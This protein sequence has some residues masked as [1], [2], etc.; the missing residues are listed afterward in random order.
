[1]ERRKTM[2]KNCRGLRGTHS[3][4]GCQE[5]VTGGAWSCRRRTEADAPKILGEYDAVLWPCYVEDFEA[6][7]LSL[8]FCILTAKS[9]LWVTCCLCRIMLCHKMQH[10]CVTF[11]YSLAIYMCAIVCTCRLLNTD[12][13]ICMLAESSSISWYA[14]PP[15]MS[16]IWAVLKLRY[17]MENFVMI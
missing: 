12:V 3:I 6:F 17:S 9:E 11:L 2:G 13:S 10:R 7:V 5:P 8:A 16:L 1:M 15:R 14:L 4:S